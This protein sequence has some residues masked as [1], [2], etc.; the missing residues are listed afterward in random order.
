[1]K[2]AV[3]IDGFNLYYHMDNYKFRRYKWLNFSKLFRN[4][5]NSRDNLS[6]H[7]FTTINYED[8]LAYKNKKEKFDEKLKRHL[9]L[10]KAEESFGVIVHYG[11]FK[12]IEF[13][14]RKCGH[15]NFIR[16]E[17]QTDVGIGSYL[18]YLAFSLNI[19]KFIILSGDT[20][21]IS[22]IKI[23]K[24]N[25]KQIRIDLVLPPGDTRSEIS[26]YCNNT[27]ILKEDVLRDSLFPISFEN[28]QKELIVCPKEWNYI[29]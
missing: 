11:Y 9:A 7:Y 29:S 26:D 8:I 17:K 23:V 14:C 22:A 6:I 10:I 1:M 18:T 21:L 16:R 4:Y 28:K 27:H 2:V 13:T 24:E 12:D 25:T 20:D 15:I 19:E 3:L 5:V